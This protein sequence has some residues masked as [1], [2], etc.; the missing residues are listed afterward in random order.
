MMS[1]D[2]ILAGLAEASS[3]FE[4]LAIA[5]HAVFLLAAL[6][7]LG[8]WRPSRRTCARLVALLPAS[9]AAV[10]AVQGNPFNAVV[11]GA[12]AV[13]LAVLA[14]WSGAEPVAPAPLVALIPAVGLI[15]AGLFYPD[16]VEGGRWRVLVAAP[17]GVL[18]CP[19]LYAA[20]GLALAGN[21]GR[22]AWTDVL[23]AAALFY[24]AIGVVVLD[25][26]FDLGLVA[27][28]LTLLAYQLISRIGTGARPAPR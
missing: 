18:P 21:L 22:R 25:V 13:A 10:A 17:V 6:A 20:V 5:W 8:G 19:T 14:Q 4:R 1:A 12:V 2:E 9:A 15:A 24:G 11:L 28:A 26:R 16:F 23:A 3:R 27:G 7:L